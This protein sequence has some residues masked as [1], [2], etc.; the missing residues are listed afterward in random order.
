MPFSCWNLER[1]IYRI[2]LLVMKESK[3]I[4]I[5]LIKNSC[6]AILS[7]TNRALNRGMWRFRCY[8]AL[9]KEDESRLFV[10]G[11]AGVELD[12]FSV[13]GESC[14]GCPFSFV[15]LLTS[16]LKYGFT[17]FNPIFVAEPAMLTL[18]NLLSK[19]KA[20]YEVRSKSSFLSTLKY[21]IL[22]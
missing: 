8:P 16:S 20:V 3:I 18:S 9:K 10:I 13:V 11:L 19:F 17:A 5:P 1:L 4:S 7:D 15:E 21:L 14:C 22:G 6:H 2:S 12:D